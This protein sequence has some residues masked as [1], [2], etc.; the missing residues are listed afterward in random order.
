MKIKIALLL[1]SFCSSMLADGYFVSIG[2]GAHRMYSKD[3]VTWTDHA[4]VGKPGHD[5]NDLKGLA[6]G[7]G[8]TVVIGGF[9]KSNIF[10]TEDGKKW[11][12]IKFN[13]GVLSG[14]IFHKK[15]FYVFNEGGRIAS[16]KDG[17]K[18]KKLTDAKVGAW[19]KEEAKKLGL[20][21]LKSNIRMWKFA[22]DTF[23]GAG[24][25]GVVC[26]TKD[27]KKFTIQKVGGDVQRFRLASNGKAFVAVD[28]IKAAQKAFYSTDGIEWKDISP[29]LSGREKIKDVVFDGERFILKIQNYGLES[30]DGKNWKKI[31]NATFPGTLIT[32]PKAYFSAGPWYRYTKDPKVSFDKGKTWKDCKFPADAAMRYVLYIEN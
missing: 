17:K 14:V 15:Q 16:S 29:K 12:K 25:N 4:F 21:K 28:N 10:V 26:T 7:N 9:S 27:F 2:N 30:T 31:K 1:I 18:W 20:D 19:A 5:Q 24:D 13:I 22:N 8:M 32:T 23:V 11:E 6:H 3:G